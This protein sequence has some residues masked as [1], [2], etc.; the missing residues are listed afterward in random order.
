MSG[1]DIAY[2]AIC[3]CTCHEMS[4]TD[5]AYLSDEHSMSGTAMAYGVLPAYA[6][7]M[8]CAV[9]RQRMPTR[10]LSAARY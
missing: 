9:P 1:I 7:A 3:L 4:V 2:G 10:V 6:P 5:T 8:R